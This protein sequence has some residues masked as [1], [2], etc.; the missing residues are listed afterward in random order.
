MPDTQYIEQFLGMLAEQ[1]G[2]SNNTLSAYHN[3]LTQ[4]STFLDSP[5]A[6]N[7]PPTV[8][9][10]DVTRGH[11]IAFLLYIK[12]RNYAATSVARKQ[13]AIKSFFRFLV[14]RQVLAASPSEELASPHVDRARPHTISSSQVDL[15]VA[16]LNAPNASPDTLRDRA[17]LQ[18]IY[19][20]GLRVGEMVALNL[21]DVDETVGTV[22]TYGRGKSRQVALGSGPA[23]QALHEYI[24]RG[25]PVL[26]RARDAGASLA[27]AREGQEGAEQEPL[28]LNH[29][30]Q[31]LTRQGFWLILKGYAKSVGLEGVT[32]HTLRHSF[33]A[34]KINSGADV[35][36]LQKMLGHASL[37]TTQ[38]YARMGEKANRKAKSGGTMRRNAS[39]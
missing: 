11:V 15:L 38:V 32:P 1:E 2:F 27:D 29:R 10:A 4:F 30:G 18:L 22:A 26:A 16:R 25:R 37:S 3:D 39:G 33:A 8:S 24:E 31:R 12:E 14:S 34:Q 20:T 23:A 28:F 13:A 19:A 6:A 36:D 7:L 35:R 17:M 21:S 9:W 5:Q